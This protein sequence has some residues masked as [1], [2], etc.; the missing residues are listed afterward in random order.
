MCVCSYIV[1]AQALLYQCTN[2]EHRG[3]VSEPVLPF[4]VP[5]FPYIWGIDL[6]TRYAWQVSFP[7]E[8][9]FNAIIPFFSLNKFYTDFLPIINHP[10]KHHTRLCF[11]SEALLVITLQ[12]S[13]A[14]LFLCILVH[15]LLHSLGFLVK[16]S[17]LVISQD[18]SFSIDI[19]LYPHEIIKFV[20]EKVVSYSLLLILAQ[21]T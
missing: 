12:C 21:N 10:E 5:T 17:P 6:V 8:T 14:R 19:W 11:N 15:V 4:N 9:S 2:L 20:R 18:Y 3:Q 7:P 13:W 1:C 16:I